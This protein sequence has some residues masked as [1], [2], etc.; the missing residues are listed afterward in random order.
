MKMRKRTLLTSLCVL[1]FLSFCTLGLCSCKMGKLDFSVSEAQLHTSEYGH[2]A[3]IK[4]TTTCTSESI[5]DSSYPHGIEGG[6]PTLILPD[7]TELEFT[8][9]V[10]TMVT[11][12]DM[13]K[14]DYI[15]QTWEF[16]FPD[17]ADYDLSEGKYAIRVEWLGESETIDGIRFTVAE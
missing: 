9:L 8:C 4:V 14:G 11:T 6:N 15:E 12:L 3:T 2:Y 16:W 5:Y 1:L 10:N 13:K 7:G 17:D